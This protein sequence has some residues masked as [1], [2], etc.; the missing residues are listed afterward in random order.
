MLLKLVQAILVNILEAATADQS[1]IEFKR[2]P[3]AWLEPS[4]TLTH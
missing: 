4:K 2:S 1:V 3:H